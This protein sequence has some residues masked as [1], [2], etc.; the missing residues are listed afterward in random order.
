[1]KKTIKV[2]DG[3][4]V[5]Q[6]YNLKLILR[7]GN[8]AIYGI[9]KDSR[10]VLGGVQYSHYEVVRIRTQKVSSLGAVRPYFERSGYT[11][12]ERYPPSSKWGYDGFTYI[13]YEDA[14]NRFNKMCK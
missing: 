1:M 7:K 8:V 14:L 3:R 11:H 12:I 4:F 2:I 9:V 13:K 5:Y 10:P 6:G